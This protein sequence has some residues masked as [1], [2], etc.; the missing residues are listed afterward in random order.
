MPASE[1]TAAGLVKH[2]TGVERVWFG[3]D[4]AVVD[5][6]RPWAEHDPHCR[7]SVEPGETLADLVAEYI[8]ECERL[9]SWTCCGC[10]RGRCRPSK[11]RQWL[12]RT[13]VSRECGS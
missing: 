8:A 4:Y 7:F 2:L 5:L 10:R 1:L 6:P 12:W 9:R 13:A 3:I 11:V